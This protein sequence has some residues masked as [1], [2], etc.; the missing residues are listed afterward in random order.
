MPLLTIT[1][2]TN[3]QVS[4]LPYLRKRNSDNYLNGEDGG[5]GGAEDPAEQKKK[6][7]V[8][9]ARLHP[10]ETHSSFVIHSIINFLLSNDT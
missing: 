1:N 6:V 7:I 10:G 9:M 3:A 4:Q 8:I 5:A 2:E